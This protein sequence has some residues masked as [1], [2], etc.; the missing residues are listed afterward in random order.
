MKVYDYVLR[1][2]VE[3]C[4]AKELYQNRFDPVYLQAAYHDTAARIE[5]RVLEDQESPD[6]AVSAVLA[7]EF[8]TDNL[9]ED[10]LIRCRDR[11]TMLWDNQE[12]IL[13]GF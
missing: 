11:M 4:P 2:L 5:N 8:G 1:V 7:D 3:E 9:R 12:S 10:R 6:F 13:K